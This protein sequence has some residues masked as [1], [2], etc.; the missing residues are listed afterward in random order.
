MPGTAAGYLLDIKATDCPGWRQG[1]E[2]LDAAVMALLVNPVDIADY[3]LVPVNFIHGVGNVY[4]FI[5]A[6]EPVA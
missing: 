5:E 3:L 2:N 4:G 6:G 1:Q